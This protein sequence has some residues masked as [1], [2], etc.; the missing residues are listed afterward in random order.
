MQVGPYSFPICGRVKLHDAH[1][2]RCVA[3]L[4]HLSQRSVNSPTQCPRVFTPLVG[5]FVRQFLDV[6]TQVFEGGGI[7]LMRGE[8]S[9]IP[10]ILQYLCHLSIMVPSLCP[11]SQNLVI[12]SA[13]HLLFTSIRPQPLYSLRL[14]GVDSGTRKMAPCHIYNI[15]T[16][17]ICRRH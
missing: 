5:V 3:R 10:W 12:M 17:I 2:A 16:D 14:C 8:L 13:R 4:R 1:H 6:G 9:R 15:M 7:C 11:R